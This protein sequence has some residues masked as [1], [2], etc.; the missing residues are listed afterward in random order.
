MKFRKQIIF[1]LLIGFFS[2]CTKEFLEVDD[3]QRL[4][5]ESYVKD[6]STMQEYVNGIYFRLSRF[7]ES[8]EAESS[9]AELV[10]D[11]LKPA[12]PTSAPSVAAHYNWVQGE[13]N[14]NMTTLWQNTYLTIRMCSFVIEE[15]DKYAGENMSQANNL[16]GQA[17]AIRALLHFK[18]VNVFSQT[19][20]FTPDGS[21]LGIPYII[22]SDIT[23]S[24]NRLT[25]SEVYDKLISDVE[26]A[27]EVLPAVSSDTRYMNRNA[28]KALLARTYLF[29]GDYSSAKSLA[30]EVVQQVPLMSIAEGYPN[31]IYK[32]KEPSKTESLFQLSPSSASNFLGR[33]VRRNPILYVAT[34]DIAQLINENSNDIRKFWITSTATGWRITKFPTN[35]AP[36]ANPVVSSPEN[37]YYPVIIRSSEMIL[38]VAEAAAK[39]ND[40]GTANEFI[41]AI[42]KRSDPLISDLNATGQALLD[43]IYKERRKE[44]AF[45]GLRLFDLMR[46][47]KPVNR[48]DAVQG[49]PNTLSYPNNKA[50]SPI[51]YQE[52]RLT[53]LPQ[54]D[55]Y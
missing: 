4:F 42:R 12:S 10:A 31:D 28:A 26:S 38:T 7:F 13:F 2:N 51:P 14:G 22:S 17:L 8:R 45:E 37:A 50:I 39:T 16:K 48:M 34:D 32:L 18:L 54:N 24:Y 47:G 1:L 40:E 23:D 25:V 41:N 6:I 27:I 3:T 20:K 19:Y 33:Y 44:L 11:N 35:A 52:V 30:L 5:R 9:Y 15:V 49:A 43:S 53:G 55:G 46:V 29:K 36:E 21:H